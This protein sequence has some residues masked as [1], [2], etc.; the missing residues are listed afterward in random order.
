MIFFENEK[1]KIIK[2]LRKENTILKQ[3]VDKLTKM[4]D[5]RVIDNK[6]ERISLNCEVDILS[7]EL[8][9]SN[10]KVKKCKNLKREILKGIKNGYNKGKI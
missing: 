4:Y 6:N 7:Y 2:E 5:S 10:L 8:V 9:K 1:D 3:K